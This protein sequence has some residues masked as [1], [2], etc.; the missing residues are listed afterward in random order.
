M[1]SLHFS[2]IFQVPQQIF[3]S[4]NKE[5]LLE[6]TYSRKELMDESIPSSIHQKM[7]KNFLQMHSMSS[8]SMYSS[9]PIFY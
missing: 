2:P 9:S 4:H 8:F 3:Q 5:M 7:N 6:W 1:E